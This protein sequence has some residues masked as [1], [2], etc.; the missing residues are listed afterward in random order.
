MFKKYISAIIFS[1][2]FFCFASSQ[3]LENLK[4]INTV[5]ADFYKA[6][7]ELDINY[8]KKIHSEDLIRIPGGNRILDY[9]TFMDRYALQ[10][11]NDKLTDQTSE[12]SLRFFERLNTN[13][14]ASERGI[15]KLI[16][17]K[18]KSDEQVF[19]GQ[20]HVLMQ[21]TD[22]SWKIIMDYDSN[23]FGTIGKND[24]KKA[25]AIDDFASL[26]TN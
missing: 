17:N 10:F 25:Y 4:E 26:V 20:F 6:F 1:I 3:T 22:G 23:E 12:I 11:R 18:G 9:N 8:M 19:Y 14:K 5:W 16:R 21:K 15:Y 24:F 7:K 13:S 2:V